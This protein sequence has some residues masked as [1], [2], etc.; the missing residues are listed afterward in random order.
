MKRTTTSLA[1]LALCVAGSTAQAQTLTRATSYGTHT[2]NRPVMIDSVNVNNQ[3]FTLSSLLKT[4]YKAEDLKG[5]SITAAKSG[6]FALPQPTRG[7]S[8]FSSYSFS[9]ISPTFTKGTL[10]LFGRARYAVYDGEELLGSNEE[11]LAE[12]DTVPA[13]SI[14]LTLIAT[15]Q[16]LVV[17]V[18]ATSEDKARADFK[19]VFEPEE[20]LPQL[21]LKAAEEGIRYINWNYLNHGK[22]LYYSNVSPS[23]K[24]VLVTYSQRDPKK[25]VTYQELRDGA[26]GK[27][28][29]S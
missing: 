10:K 22:R 15:N 6:Y 2:V 21:D 14:P 20:G 18:L 29:W 3:K 13:V 19:L 7:A 5:T 9:L 26:T 8:T 4:A 12:S 24:Y 16:D 27:V 28:L 23:G 11:T 1:L 25:G 17:K